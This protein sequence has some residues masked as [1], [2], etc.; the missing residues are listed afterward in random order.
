M[1]KRKK[2]VS[3]YKKK[4][5][6]LPITYQK[7][8]TRN[9]S[10]YHLLVIQLNDKKLINNRD[11]IFASLKAKNIGVNLHY[12]PVHLH[13]HYKKLGFKK[14]DFPNA[15]DYARKAITLPLHPKLTIEQIDYIVKALKET[16]K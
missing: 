11:K 16:V 9:T 2:L 14:G 6:D 13:P 4:L 12:Y 7:I 10:A 5:A 15:E 8:D 1:L 3:I